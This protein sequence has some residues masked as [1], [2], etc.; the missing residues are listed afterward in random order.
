MEIVRSL[1]KVTMETTLN[2][3]GCY[4]KAWQWALQIWQCM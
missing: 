2:T 4:F 3:P 1:I